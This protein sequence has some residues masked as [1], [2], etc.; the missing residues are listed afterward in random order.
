MKTIGD[1]I[2]SFV[3]KAKGESKGEKFIQMDTE[4]DLEGQTI[5]LS[6]SQ[7]QSDK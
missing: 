2:G 7:D 1:K 5:K 4:A 6:E 3:A